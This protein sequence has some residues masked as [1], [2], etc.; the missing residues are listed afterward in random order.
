MDEA[1]CKVGL[2]Y[3]W[4]DV[5]DGS[6][7]CVMR[8]PRPTYEGDLFE[9]LLAVNHPPGGVGF[10]VRKSAALEVSGFDEDLDIGE[11][12]IFL[13]R[14]AQRFQIAV[15]PQVIFRYHTGHG[16]KRLSDRLELG[17]AKYIRAHMHI[18]ADELDKRPKTRALALRKLAL[19]EMRCGNW[20][21]SL[22]AVAASF[23]LDPLGTT[24]QGARYFVRS[25]YRFLRAPAGLERR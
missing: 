25:C 12:A 19:T 16:H 18:F 4:R 17:R 2:V 9:H 13:A 6:T 11:D 23:R 8:G 20:R 1:S 3:G 7:G 10:M 22:S 15:V 24:D 21:A 5:V 14:I